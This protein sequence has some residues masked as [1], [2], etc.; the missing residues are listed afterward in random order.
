MIHKWFEHKGRISPDKV[1]AYLEEQEVY[2]EENREWRGEWIIW[3]KN[4]GGCRAEPGPCPC[5][6]VPKG[7]EKPV[8]KDYTTS[9][10]D[11][12]NLCDVLEHPRAGDRWAEFNNTSID[13]PLVTEVQD[14]QPNQNPGELE[15]KAQAPNQGEPAPLADSAEK[16]VLRT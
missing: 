12:C 5:P 16:E 4:H 1:L 9:E 3:S 13:G 7:P 15:E 11:W 6:P 10:E 2:E 14:G 8:L